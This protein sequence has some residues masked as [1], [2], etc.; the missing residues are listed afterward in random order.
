MLCTSAGRLS[1]RA[2]LAVLVAVTVLTARPLLAATA[3]RTGN[4]TSASTWGG[5]VPGANESAT[6]PAGIT[7][8]IPSGASV[9]LAPT[10]EGGK[11]DVF[12]TLVV[13]GSLLVLDV[14]IESG[15]TL[16]NNA[17]GSITLDRLY[18]NQGTVVNKG[19]I[20]TQ[21]PFFYDYAAFTND[22]GATI[23]N[24]GQLNLNS[25]QAFV[26]RGTVT[27]NADLEIYSP[28]E[29][30]GTITNASGRTMTVGRAIH[31]YSGAKISNLGA[32]KVDGCGP[33]GFDNDGT[34]SNSGTSFDNKGHIVNSCTGVYT[35][36]PPA[37]NQ[38]TTSCARGASAP[39]PQAPTPTPAVAS[40]PSGWTNLGW[41]AADISVGANG[42][43]WFVDASGAIF[44]LQNGNP[45]RVDGQAA[46]IAV[47][48]SG[49]PWVVN[50]GGS[51]FR[52]VGSAW[53]R[54]PGS[55]KDVGI[56]GNG[57][58]WILGA[59]GAPASW[60]GTGWTP[61]GSGA[62]TRIAVDPAGALWVVNAEHKIW[63]YTGAWTGIPG[64]ALDVSVG[65]DGTVYVVG[66]G[67]GTGGYQIWRYA[68]G[69][70]TQEPGVFGSVVAA[71]RG[72]R[73]F[74]GRS[75]ASGLPV[76]AR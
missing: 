33:C 60:N 3:V 42:S 30:Y 59:D 29:N 55:A 1:G 36:T 28:I 26:N 15:G 44:R 34:L 65:G 31:N 73:A 6:I 20:L 8:T 2:V 24:R 9:T 64:E 58:V 57:K 69:A 61:L 62:G 40:A 48:P 25:N 12:G 43:V 51:L 10:G 56:G 67:A 70:W 71:G 68:G 38:P 45:V 5:A 66:A 22:R 14:L 19:K 27:N 49:A 39:A 50:T 74:V 47:D 17:T 35:G 76:L 75:S 23:E 21:A 72:L 7:V 11:I 63:R 16:T 37:G 53:Q 18:K 32:V 13:S 52:W 54:L 41:K 4:W 46:R